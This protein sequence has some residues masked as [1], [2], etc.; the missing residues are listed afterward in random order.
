M[1][2]HLHT[3]LHFTVYILQFNGA[4]IPNLPPPPPPNYALYSR[5][6]ST[7]PANFNGVNEWGAKFGKAE[8]IRQALRCRFRPGGTFTA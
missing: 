2:T 4:V 3:W 6:T 7:V 5:H 8:L 1:A